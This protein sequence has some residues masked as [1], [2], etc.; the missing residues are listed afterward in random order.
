MLGLA[1]DCNRGDTCNFSHPQAARWLQ[2]LDASGYAVDLTSLLPED[3]AAVTV[4]V[5]FTHYADLSSWECAQQLVRA[6]P[7]LSAQV[8]QS[9]LIV[10]NIP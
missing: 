6:L 3:A 10:S 8:S 9:P 1:G 7:D 5:F 4:L 2:V